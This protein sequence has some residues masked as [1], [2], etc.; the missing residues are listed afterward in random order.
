MDTPWQC[1]GTSSALQ[2]KLRPEQVLAGLRR[3]FS[4]VGAGGCELSGT[5]FHADRARRSGVA[6]VRKRDELHALNATASQATKPA[7]E[8][9]RQVGG[10][11]SVPRSALFQLL[12]SVL[13][14]AVQ[15]KIAK[16]AMCI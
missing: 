14:V 16:Y 7:I 5:L 1:L 10:V 9:K 3:L 4:S 15:Q 8:S 13:P 2:L 12:L 11:Q 6:H